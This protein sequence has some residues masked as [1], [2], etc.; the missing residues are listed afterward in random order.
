MGRTNQ[1]IEDNALEPVSLQKNSPLTNKKSA[2]FGF[3]KS[4]GCKDI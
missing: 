2:M 1:Q 3:S 4:P